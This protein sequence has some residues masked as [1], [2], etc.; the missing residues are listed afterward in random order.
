ME[1]LVGKTI[2]SYRIESVIGRGGMGI[3]YKATDVALDKEVVLKMIDPRLVQDKTFLKRF[4]TEPKLQ[5]KLESPYIVQ[6][7][8]FRQTQ[9]GL[10][11]VMEY[12]DGGTLSQMIKEKGPLPV[13]QALSIFRKILLAIDTAHQA[14]IIH[15]DI[16]PRNV[17]ISRKGD[18]KVTDFGLAKLQRATEATVTMTAAGTLNYMPP[19]QIRGLVHV[20]HR[21]DIY[22]LGMTLYEMLAGRVPFPKDATE[23][24]VLKMIMEEPLPPPTEFNPAI[25]QALSDIVMKALEK[26]PDRRYQ[27]IPEMME[28]LEE[29]EKSFTGELMSDYTSPTEKETEFLPPVVKGLESETPK[30]PPPPPPSS[31]SRRWWIGAF[32]LLLFAGAAGYWFVGRRPSPPPP[33]DTAVL[34]LTSVPEGATVYRDGQA[35]GRT[36]LHQAT[37]PAGEYTLEVRKSGFLPWKQEKVRF[38]SGSHRTL[39]AVLKPIETWGALAISSDPPGGEV[40]IDNRRAGQTPLRLDS[41]APG[42]YRVEVRLKDYLPWR[43]EVQV[44]PDV[45]ARITARLQQ[46]KP[47]LPEVQTGTLSLTIVPEG[48]IYVDGR[49]QGR[50]SVQ[51]SVPA[52][53]HQV[54]FEHPQYG[55]ATVPVEVQPDRVTPLTYYFEA[56]LSIVTLDENGEPLWATLVLNGEDTGEIAARDRYPLGVGTYR[57]SVKR[58]GY[59]VLNEEEV[60]QVNPGPEKKEYNLTFRLRKR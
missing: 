50:K 6:V 57:I 22:S 9:Q 34:T 43:K 41:L 53:T 52:G 3:V 42:T 7:Y 45:P 11:I 5:A 36:P 35:I 49:L 58:V 10:F 33:P 23:Y 1:D 30:P 21:S 32:V 27:S 15:R 29:F 19:E 60:I 59:E 25:P 37:I 16:K 46:R 40:W 20:D 17:L 8:A 39:R 47:P 28:A 55:K 51:L 12:V 2:D 56:Y 44:S 24:M 31:P 14:G 18:V 38:D 13:A 4:L 26:E 54:T 48:R